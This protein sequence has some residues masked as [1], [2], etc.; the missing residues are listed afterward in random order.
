MICHKIWCN[1]NVYERVNDIQ[2]GRSVLNFIAYFWFLLIS[3]LL[4]KIS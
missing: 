3:R 1:G 2:F 4:E